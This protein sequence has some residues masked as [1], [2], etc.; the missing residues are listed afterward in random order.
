MSL[1]LNLTLKRSSPLNFSTS[2]WYLVLN[3]KRKLSIFVG[4]STNLCFAL[5]NMVM[6]TDIFHFESVYIFFPLNVTWL[7]IYMSIY[8][9]VNVAVAVA[10]CTIGFEP[11]LERDTTAFDRDTLS[12]FFNFV[13]QC[14]GREKNVA[15]SFNTINDNDGA[16]GSIL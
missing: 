11:V 4:F 9:Y 2:K 3:K 16:L 8:A 7:T 12:V 5:D 15:F 13:P 14:I 6:V 10:S 1:F